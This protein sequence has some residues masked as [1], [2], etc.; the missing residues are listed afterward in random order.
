VSALVFMDTETTGL[1][2]TDDI[3]E[4]AAVRRNEDGTESELHMFLEHDA[5]KCAQLP[6]KFRDD[7]MRRF[8]PSHGGVE[9]AS[10][11]YPKDRAGRA[12]VNFF[13]V[14]SGEPKPHVVGAVPN[15]DTERVNLLLP[16]YERDPWHYH[17]ID[18]E[19][20]AVGA[21]VARRLQGHVDLSLPWDSD[22]LST[23]V[24]VVPTQFERHTAMGDV[25]WAMA[26]YD[27]VMSS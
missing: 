1:S 9:W 20:L 25:R 11:V 10:G 6:E 8:P 26:I 18:V 12:I 22:E 16:N 7:H 23:A 27:A 13:R 17:L 5:N 21:L 2:L 4:F 15:F 14:A 3:W 19:S 24:G